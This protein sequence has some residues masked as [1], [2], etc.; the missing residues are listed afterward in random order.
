LHI[1]FTKGKLLRQKTVPPPLYPYSNENPR[2]GV[3]G[4]RGVSVRKGNFYVANYD[5]IFV[6]DK[7]F[8]FKKHITHPLF[9]G[10][11]EIEVV[12]DGIWATSTS[13]DLLLKVD[14]NGKLLSYWYYR[15]NK[16][17][18]KKIGQS[19]VPLIDFQ[20]DYRRDLKGGFAVLKLAHINNVRL[21]RDTKLI[22]TLGQCAVDK[23][24]F[25]SYVIMLDTETKEVQIIYKKRVTFP[26][27][28]AQMLSER[29]LIVNDSH[30]MT[31]LLIDLRTKK[32]KKKIKIPGTWLRGLAVKD[33]RH[34]IVGS[35]PAGIYEIDLQRETI[36][37]FINLSRNPHESIHGLCILKPTERGNI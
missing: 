19:A 8:R 30:R 2:G 22:V 15:Q 26:M 28:N 10:L 24:A 18:L 35:S 13:I 27:H 31:T 16:D 36:S 23:Q 37:H 1:D 11:H 21:Y 34:V 3:R 25:R 14:F 9:S 12:R 17:F 29:L 32:I 7:K 5:S 20:N 33:N 6:Y 4:G